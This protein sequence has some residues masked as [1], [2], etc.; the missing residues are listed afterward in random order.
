MENYAQTETTYV[1]A[2][3]HEVYLVDSRGATCQ[4]PASRITYL[5]PP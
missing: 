2:L 5:L 3:R 1:N 4:G